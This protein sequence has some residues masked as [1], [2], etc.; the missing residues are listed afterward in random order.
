MQLSTDDTDPAGPTQIAQ[1]STDNTGPPSLIEEL[2]N[3][4]LTII[5]EAGFRI[6]L[7]DDGL[8]FIIIVS[9]VSR[10]WRAVAFSFPDAWCHVPVHPGRDAMTELFLAHSAGRPLEISFWIHETTSSERAT[11]TLGLIAPSAPRW[12]RLGIR[13]YCWWNMP[14]PLAQFRAL[15]DTTSLCPFELWYHE[16]DNNVVE[17]PADLLDTP[18][19][20]LES[21]TCVG[22]AIKYHSPVFYGLTRLTLAHPHRPSHMEFRALCTQSPRLQY[23]KLENVFPTTVRYIRRVWGPFVLNSLRTLEVVMDMEEETGI[24]P[25]IFFGAL[26]APALRKLSF[27]SKLQPM[28]QSFGKAIEK[29]NGSLSPKHLRTLHLV[30]T[31]PVDFRHV[32]VSLHLFHAF[33]KLEYLFFHAFD[34]ASVLCFLRGGIYRIHNGVLLPHAVWPP[35][36]SLTIHMPHEDDQAAGHETVQESLDLL[37]KLRLS[38]GQ[39]FRLYVGESTVDPRD[40][41]SGRRQ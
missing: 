12:T 25:E 9:H 40:L 33:P 10:R 26:I 28:W 18:S 27:E 29:W 19:P 32:T 31:G 38:S 15:Q 5:F 30:V 7:Q 22:S 16:H 2:L 24:Y 39:R 34:N 1:P 8:P 21:V 6:T 23:L 37:E 17:E 35:L 4:L 11:K 41:L 14:Y 3:E 13:A 36:K 20:R